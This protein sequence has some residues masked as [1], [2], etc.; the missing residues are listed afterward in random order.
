[1]YRT[2]AHVYLYKWAHTVPY[3]HTHMRPLAMILDLTIKFPDCEEILEIDKQ[4]IRSQGKCSTKS[5]V[6]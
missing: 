1:M 3:T 4:V 6:V 5:S 2:H